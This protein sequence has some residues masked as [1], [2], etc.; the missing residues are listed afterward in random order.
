MSNNQ[1]KVEIT[2]DAGKFVRGMKSAKTS[3]NGVG[4]SLFSVKNAVIGLA[5]AGGFG[6]LVKSSLQTVDALAK[7]SDKLGI[8]TE[9]LA[10]LRHAAEQTG[11]SS[12]TLDMALQ[13]MTRRIAEAARGTGEAK[14]ALKEL[15]LDARALANSSPDKAFSAI[16]ESMTDVENQSDKVRLAFKLFDSE[17][18]NLVN[19]LDLGKEGLNAAALEAEQFGIAINRVDA[20]KIERA[21]NALLKVKASSKGIGQQIAVGLSPHIE[22]AADAFLN[23]S[24]SAGGLD[25]IVNDTVTHANNI[26]VSFFAAIDKGWTGVAQMGEASAATV[27]FAWDSAISSIEGLWG[28]LLGSLATGLDKIGLDEKA[29]SMRQF[30]DAIKA[31]S[32]SLQPLG[33]QLD[34]IAEKFIR[35]REVVDN[36]AMSIIALN[37]AAMSI[38]ALNN[39]KAELFNQD[40]ASAQS[41]VSGSF[42]ETSDDTKIPGVLGLTENELEAELIA[43]EKQFD[44]LDK[45]H[46]Q[47]ADKQLR[48][49]QQKSSLILGT[50]STFTRA[51][52]DFINAL[53]GEHKKASKIIFAIEKGLAIAQAVVSTEVAAAKAL[54]IDQTGALSS[55]VRGVGYAS[56][57][58]IAGTALLGGGGGSGAGSSIAPTS[59]S[60]SAFDPVNDSENQ[61]PGATGGSV[62]VN[63]NGMMDERMIQDTLIPA[64]Q[65]AVSFGDVILIKGDSRNASEIIR[66]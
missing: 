35:E 43:V 53:P 36:A 17:G 6:L 42:E 46:Q 58:L 25:V 50:L 3:L 7:T 64:L 55:W 41:E 62:T 22:S 51:A 10:A 61:Q 4:S 63:I 30:S 47:S 34:E 14:D 9:K 56:V 24:K 39:A 48:I 40:A 32:E 60:Q 23:M 15:G 11:V 38:I 59:F 19:T 44:E 37:N 12:N 26:F 29:L 1:Y 57:G 45:L 13:R 49:E 66:G 52:S 65:D 18:V 33:E 5:G 8:T 31:S 27:M 54:T 2:A 28:T 20:A 16:A 21:N